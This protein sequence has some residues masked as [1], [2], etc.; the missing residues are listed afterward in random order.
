M[1]KLNLLNKL[2]GY[3]ARQENRKEK[4]A[5]PGSGCYLISTVLLSVERFFTPPTLDFPFSP[6]IG[7][8]E[9]NFNKKGQGRDR[10]YRCCSS[11]KKGSLSHASDSPQLS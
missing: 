11:N 5:Y 4:G 10:S 2:V 6:F 7:I 8:F 1:A 3:D 9:K